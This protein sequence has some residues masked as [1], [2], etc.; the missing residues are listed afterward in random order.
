MILSA[1]LSFLGGSAFRM[2]WGELSS[3]L[4]KT[5]DHAHEIERL[6]LEADL[7]DRRAER[8]AA[9]IRLQAELNVQ[10]VEVQ[11]AADEAKGAADA[12]TAAMSNAFKPT[13]IAWVDIW[14]GVIRPAYASFFLAL[15][16]LKVYAQGWKM[17]EWDASMAG[18]VAGFFFAD[19]SLMKRG[20]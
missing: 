14:N 1:L 2:I 5:T 4:N 7:E 6:R 10:Q 9:N 11:S 15:I 18:M 3:F 17:D 16:V 13:G 20:R 19:R 12:F 8:T